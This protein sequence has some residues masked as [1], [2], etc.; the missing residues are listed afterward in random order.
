MT[1][2]Q[3]AGIA[4]SVEMR[5]ARARLKHGLRAHGISV[6]QALGEPC[7]KSMTV[8][9]LVRARFARGSKYGHA[10][11][12]RLLAEVDVLLGLGLSPYRRVGDLTDRQKRALLQACGENG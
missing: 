11:T 7:A 6:A 1:D 8:Y 12:E 3:L 9:D 5:E 10:Q 4:R 2:K